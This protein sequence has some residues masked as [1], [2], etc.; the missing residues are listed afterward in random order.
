MENSDSS[1]DEDEARSWRELTS[2]RVIRS[3]EAALVAMYVM[4]SESMPKEVY[5]EDVIERVCQLAKFQLNNSIYPEYDPV[6]KISSHKKGKR[7]R[8]CALDSDRI[9]LSIRKTHCREKNS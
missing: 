6:Y 2:E 8:L 7:R 3:T 5:V 4:T 9:P 1:D